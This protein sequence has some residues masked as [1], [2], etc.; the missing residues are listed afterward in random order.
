MTRSKDMIPELCQCLRVGSLEV[1]AAGHPCFVILF[2]FI[3][4]AFS[5]KR[6]TI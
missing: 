5:G 1:D 6:E 2:C 3:P 4:K